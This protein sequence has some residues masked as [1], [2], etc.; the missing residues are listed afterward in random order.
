MDNI[1]NCY[2]YKRT[3]ISVISTERPTK[4]TGHSLTS[5]INWYQSATISKDIASF[6]SLHTVD[7]HGTV[8]AQSL[9]GYVYKNNRYR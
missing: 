7:I 1:Q 2:S 4:D 6:Y 9:R 3:K 5:E 8:F